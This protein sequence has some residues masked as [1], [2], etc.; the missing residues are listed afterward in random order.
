MYNVTFMNTTNTIL[1]YYSGV[2]EASGDMLS[3]IILIVLWIG[4]FIV[5]KYYDTKVA[6]LS[7]SLTTS[8]IAL[9]FFAAE[10]ISAGILFIP[11]VMT[12]FS[13]VALWW[14]RD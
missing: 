9:L 7:C 8:M 10:F 4:I 12:M 2:N 6:F 13:I 5:T 11:L 3:I 1:D 14:S